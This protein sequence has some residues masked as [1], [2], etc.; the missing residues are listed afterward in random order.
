MPT[1]AIIHIQQKVKVGRDAMPKKVIDHIQ[2]RMC[3]YKVEGG[4]KRGLV[5]RLNQFRNKLPQGT[6]ILSASLPVVIEPYDWN[7]NNRVLLY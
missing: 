3:D 1:K 7:S 5:F 2:Y 4:I 6:T